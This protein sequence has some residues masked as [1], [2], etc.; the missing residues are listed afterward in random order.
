M[1]LKDGDSF[2]D[3][4]GQKEFPGQKKQLGRDSL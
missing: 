3:T 1:S 4:H 2:N